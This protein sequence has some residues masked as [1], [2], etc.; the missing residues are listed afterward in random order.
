MTT[1]T[2]APVTFTR[3]QAKQADKEL[4]L[5]MLDVAAKQARVA[6][7][8]NSVHHAINDSYRTRYDSRSGWMLSE[9]EATT[10][11]A[12]LAATDTTYVGR[13]AAEALARLAAAEAELATARAA[14]DAAD[15]WATHG[16]WLRYAVVP[17]GH[18][19][20]E[21]GCFTLRWDTDVRWAYPVSGDSVAEAIETYGEALCSHCYPDAPVAQTLGKVEVDAEGHPISKAEAQAIRDAKDAEKAAKLAAKNAA[22]VVCPATG[23]VLYKTE[24]AATNAIATALGYYFSYG[25]D[26]D[27]AS[28]EADIV[29]VAAKRGVDAEALR[30]ELI[31]KAEAKFRK[32]AIKGI[33]EILA[34]PTSWNADPANWCESYQRV[35]REEGLI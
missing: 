14:R 21:M 33:K 24:R 32:T 23:R 26:K 2:P 6:S 25:N 27:L 1:T 22:A 28:V 4:Y 16:K 5:A 3:E 7:A 20:N 18:I 13:Q 9:A 12:D 34:N 30:A 15:K 10:K 17:G 35:A 29:A 8:L 19:H 31:G 11:C